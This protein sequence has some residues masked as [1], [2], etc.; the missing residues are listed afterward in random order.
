MSCYGRAAKTLVFDAPVGEMPELDGEPVRPRLLSPEEAF[1]GEA[2]MGYP[3]STEAS[4]APEHVTGRW[5]PDAV[6]FLLKAVYGILAATRGAHWAWVDAEGEPLVDP[7]ADV[8]NTLPVVKDLAPEHVK[9]ITVLAGHGTMVGK[10]LA[11]DKQ[12]RQQKTQTALAGTDRIAQ[13]AN[14]SPYGPNRLEG[15]Q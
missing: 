5:T 7:T 14:Q 1:A 4:G 11:W 10:R 12:I 3:V 6:R 9:L 15:E 8:M 13:E 2:D